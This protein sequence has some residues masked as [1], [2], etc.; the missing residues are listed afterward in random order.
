MEVMQALVVVWCPL[1]RKVRFEEASVA[2]AG[3]LVSLIDILCS[4][5]GHFVRWN[6]CDWL[7]CVAWIVAFIHGFDELVVVFSHWD[8]QL[9]DIRIVQFGKSRL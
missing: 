9:A 1:D 6:E 3:C 2:V 8:S 5:G 4:I 7:L